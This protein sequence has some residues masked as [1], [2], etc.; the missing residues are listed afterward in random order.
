MTLRIISLAL[1]GAADGVDDMDALCLLDVV[2]PELATAKGVVQPREHHWDVFKHSM[3]TVRAAGRLLD[4]AVR[5]SDPVLC[6]QVVL[7]T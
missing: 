5:R 6:E 7:S 4:G 1:P 2:L 3:E